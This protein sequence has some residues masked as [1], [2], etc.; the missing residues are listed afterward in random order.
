MQLDDGD[1]KVFS[2]LSSDPEVMGI[3]NSKSK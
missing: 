2:S 3:A 1:G